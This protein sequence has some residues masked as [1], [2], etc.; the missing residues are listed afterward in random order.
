M[1][2]I[3]ASVR[4]GFDALDLDPGLRAVAESN[5]ERWLTEPAFAAYVPALEDLVEREQFAELFDAFWQVL[6][7]GTGG[8]RGP[9]GVGPNR[10]N[11]WTL[12]TSVQGHAELLRETHPGEDVSVVVAFDVRE[13]Q[14]R[15][16]I[17]GTSRSNPL[18]GLTSRELARQAACV[19]VANGVKV[20]MPDPDGDMFLATPELSL[21]IRR[22]GAHGGLN[23]SASHNHPDDNGGKVYNHHGGQDVPPHDEILARRVESMQAPRTVPWDEALAEGRVEFLD[24]ADRS[25]YLAVVRRLAL[26]PEC[27]AGPIVFTNLHGV[28]LGSVL[29]VLEDEGFDVHLVPSQAA[30][31]GGFP[32]VAHLAPNP[33]VPT[34]YGPGEAVADACGADLILATD[35]DADRIGAEVRDAEGRW[36]FLPGNELLCLALRFVLSRRRDTARLPADA[37]VLTTIVTS[38]LLGTI[39]RSYGCTVIDDLC[40]GFKYMADVVARL[41]TSGSWRH[42]RAQPASLVFAGEEAHGLMLTPAIREKDAAAAA[43]VLAELHAVCRAEGRTLLDELDAIHARFGYV[44]NRLVNTVMTGSAGRQRMTAIQQSLR[45]DPPVEVDGRRVVALHDLADTAGWRGPLLSST[46]FANRNVLVF[47][48]GGGR[49]LVVRPSGTEPKN[50]LYVEVP[51]ATPVED[52]SADELAAQ[53]ERC[54]AEADAL[55]R[56]FQRLMLARVGL[57]LPDFAQA[58]SALVPLDRRLEFARRD[59][60]V[61]EQR[62]RQGEDLGPWVRQVFGD[63][64]ERGLFAPGVGAWL[65]SAGLPAPVEQAVR[66]AFQLPASA[67]D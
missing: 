61:L 55:G 49:R 67:G 56:A 64:D 35:P 7:F 19:Y 13:F 28:G 5:L 23:V 9:V 57:D 6:P 34:C 22:L 40:V 32:G 38:R 44:A 60:P 53:R 18:L 16:G 31:D 8:R 29:P 30:L 48:F 58:V 59:V 66:V 4:S 33:E 26:A 54:D 52:L 20:S 37:Y 1:S 50:K 3:L 11:P 15:R 63:V 17:F 24:P 43:L 21:T 27:R 36:H 25:H 39:A 47:E 65:A 12:G 45:R 51:A 14:D 62:A 42:L 41:E 10:F 2:D 46:D